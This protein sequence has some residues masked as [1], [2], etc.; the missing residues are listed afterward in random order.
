MTT[1]TYLSVYNCVIYNSEI[2]YIAIYILLMYVNT[3]IVLCVVVHRVGQYYDIIV[4]HDIKV[5]R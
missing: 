5:P 3:T 2:C 4:Y 1:T